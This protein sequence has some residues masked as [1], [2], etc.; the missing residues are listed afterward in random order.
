MTN[1][2]PIVR[3]LVLGDD[4]HLVVDECVAC[5]ARYFDRRNG[6]ASC[7]GTEFRSAAV[8][9]TGEVRAFTIVTK[10]PPEV[11]AP[12]VAA[13]V[14]CDGTTVRGSLV[15]VTPDPD[16]VRVGMAVQLTTTSL[17]TDDAGT[18]AVGFVFTPRED[19]DDG[20]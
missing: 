12:Y 10:G 5:G 8:S 18:E 19:A 20:E 14:D 1:R 15:D 9:T 11:D 17:G 16:H 2:V 3:Y 6:C 13:I 4:P 7:G